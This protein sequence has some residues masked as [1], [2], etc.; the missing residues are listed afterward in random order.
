MLRYFE[1]PQGGKHTRA[2][3]SSP[4][5]SLRSR[6]GNEFSGNDCQRRHKRVCHSSPGDKK[7]IRHLQFMILLVRYMNRWSYECASRFGSNCSG[8][9]CVCVWDQLCQSTPRARG[10]PLLMHEVA[11]FQLITDFICHM[12]SLLRYVCLLESCC[13]GC[14]R[15]GV[16]WVGGRA[17]WHLAVRMCVCFVHPNTFAPLFTSIF[18]SPCISLHSTQGPIPSSLVVSCSLAAA[19]AAQQR[20][21]LNVSAHVSYAL[22]FTLMELCQKSNAG[23]AVKQ[24]DVIHNW[25]DTLFLKHS[26]KT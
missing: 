10:W 26:W 17:R 14:W 19:A 16:G 15:W 2:N 8:M 23:K 3:H 21:L 5:A 1:L 24:R 11:V 13:G 9:N 4:L 6:R 20:Q 22:A 18:S 12:R 7:S 25:V